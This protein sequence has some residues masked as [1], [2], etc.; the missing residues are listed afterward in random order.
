MCLVNFIM[1]RP[2]SENNYEA[3]LAALLKLMFPTS[4]RNLQLILNWRELTFKKQATHML[5]L[6][7]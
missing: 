6:K 3:I 7:F 2:G 1:N 5:G 4:G